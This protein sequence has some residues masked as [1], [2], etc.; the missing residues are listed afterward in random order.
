MTDRG[1]IAIPASESF[2]LPRIALI[3]RPGSDDVKEEHPKSALGVRL[4]M[5]L[6]GYAFPTDPPRFNRTYINFS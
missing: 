2:Q 1:R 6:Y 5:R 3:I 4:Q